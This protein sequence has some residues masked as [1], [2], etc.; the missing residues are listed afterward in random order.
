MTF[1]S[2]EILTD[3]VQDLGGEPTHWIAYRRE[4]LGS[5]EDA[6]IGQAATEAKA[7]RDLLDKEESRD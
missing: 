1:P 6:I 7:I 2:R 5:L 3:Q 4:D